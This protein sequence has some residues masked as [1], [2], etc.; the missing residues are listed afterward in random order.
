MQIFFKKKRITLTRK[1]IVSEKNQFNYVQFGIH[2]SLLKN[3]QFHA[4]NFF[5]ILDQNE[6]IINSSATIKS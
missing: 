2:T 4:E 5:H 1:K 3:K 6:E